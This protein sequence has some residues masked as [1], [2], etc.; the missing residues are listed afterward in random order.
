[1]DEVKEEVSDFAEQT[2]TKVSEAKK[3]AKSANG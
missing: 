2:K 1:M 3:A